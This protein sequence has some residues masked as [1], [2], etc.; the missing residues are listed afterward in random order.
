MPHLHLEHGACFLDVCG[1]RGRPRHIRGLRSELWHRVEGSLDVTYDGGDNTLPL[2][3]RG[4]C[5]HPG[6]QCDCGC[7]THAHLLPEFTARFVLLGTFGHLAQNERGEGE[8][9]EE[10]RGGRQE[11]NEQL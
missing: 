2:D 9:G 10:L 6:A 7:R 4:D 5:I 11:G 8:G 1:L 3:C